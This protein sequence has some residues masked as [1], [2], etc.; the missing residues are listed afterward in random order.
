LVKA[1]DKQLQKDQLHGI[2]IPSEAEDHLKSLLRQRNQ[3]VKQLRKTKSH[4]KAMLLYHGVA[5]PDEFENPNWSKGFIQWLNDIAWP[6]PTG[7]AC[8]QSKIRI[9]SLLHSECLKASNELRSYC[10]RYHK[11]DYYYRHEKNRDQN[12]F[13]KNAFGCAH[14]GWHLP[15]AARP[16]S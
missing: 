4:I 15:S 5:V 13:Q 11:K 14:A 10:R 2:Y 16:F 7:T 12:E 3:L 6:Y 9:L 1:I 8:M